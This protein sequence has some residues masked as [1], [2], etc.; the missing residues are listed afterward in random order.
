MLSSDAGRAA[1]AQKELLVYSLW[2]RLV[3][4]WRRAQLLERR[5]RAIIALGLI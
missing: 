4:A 3:G 1:S 5:F 2:V